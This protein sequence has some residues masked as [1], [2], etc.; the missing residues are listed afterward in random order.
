MQA[1]ERQVGAGLPPAPVAPPVDEPRIF[2]LNEERADIVAEV[3]RRVVQ[4]KLL[5]AR[6]RQEQALEYVINDAAFSETS[7]F[8]KEG[9]QFHARLQFWRQTARNLAQASEAEKAALL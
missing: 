9:P 8:E 2:H 7:L 3:R 6:E 1:S 5:A 4:E